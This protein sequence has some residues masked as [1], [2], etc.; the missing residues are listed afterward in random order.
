M[1]VE[2]KNDITDTKIESKFTKADVNKNNFISFEEFKTVF[3]D[4]WVSQE[5]SNAE[6]E[7]KDE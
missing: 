6:S 1:E 7:K 5:D 2:N 4:L 3:A